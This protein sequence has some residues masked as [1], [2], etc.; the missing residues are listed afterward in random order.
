MPTIHKTCKIFV[1][2][3]CMAVFKKKSN[4]YTRILHDTLAEIGP[5]AGWMNVYSIFC[6]F[7]LIDTYIRFQRSA[8]VVNQYNNCMLA[9]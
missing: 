3:K 4:E 9:D 2:Y 6:M 7:I 8:I 1:Y 5:L